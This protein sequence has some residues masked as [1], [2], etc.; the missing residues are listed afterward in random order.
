MAA[1][2]SHSPDLK[3]LKPKSWNSLCSVP[4]ADNEPLS[5][6][7]GHT[8]GNVAAELLARGGGNNHNRGAS[9]SGVGSQAGGM[10]GR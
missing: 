5:H 4:S 9:T 10:S 7:G 6:A 3:G 1:E 2:A 8:A